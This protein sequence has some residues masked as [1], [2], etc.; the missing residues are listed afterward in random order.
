MSHIVSTI[1]K[2][3]IVALAFWM[4]A[5]SIS[6]SWAV[7]GIPQTTTL[8]NLSFAFGEDEIKNDVGVWRDA[9][10]LATGVWS[11]SGEALQIT[12][13]A[14]VGG[15][16]TLFL[17]VFVDDA[18]AQPSD[19][20]FYRAGSATT[21]ERSFT[22]VT[23][24]TGASGFRLVRVQWMSED[25]YTMGTRSLSV[26]SAPTEAGQSAQLAFTVPASGPP[27]P[28]TRHGSWANVPGLTTRLVTRE[29]GDLQITFS[30]EI[31][32]FKKRFLA[33]AVLDGA[34]AMPADVT[35]EQQDHSG[36][37]TR[38]M[39]F[40]R[41]NVRPGTHT[42]TIQWFTDPG[43]EIS[44]GDRTLSVLASVRGGKDGG[45]N[46]EVRET[47]PAKIESGNWTTLA[48]GVIQTG[49]TSGSA[50]VTTASVEH[51]VLGLGR[52]HMRVLVDD[53]VM[54]PGEIVLD[55]QASFGVQ[56]MVFSA[57]DFGPP[58]LLGGIYKISLQ[59]KVD[60]GFGNVG[61]GTVA[62]IR[63][64]NLSSVSVRRTGADFAQA[65]PLQ[66]GLFPAQGRFN[67]LTICFDPIRP[68][69]PPLTDAAV[70]N[71]V[72]GS[73]VGIS[74]RELY[75][76]TS[77]G[78][79]GIGNHTVLGCG[80]PTTY[81]PP[82]AHRGNYYWEGSKHNE[83][84]VQMRVDAIAAADPDFNFKQF[85][86]N[87]D[88]NILA[89]ELVINICIPQSNTP[90]FGQA[91]QFASYS[92]DGT[93]LGIATVDCYISPDPD[94]A[95]RKD[96]VGLIAHET[97]HQLEIAPYDLYGTADMPEHLSLMG[98]TSP[99]H[100]SAY[101]KLHYGWISPALIDMTAWT[102]RD[103]SIDAI[104]T[105]KEA[106]IVYNPTRNNTEYF[107]VENRFKGTLPGI[108]NYDRFIGPAAGPVLWHIV[109]DVN[110]LDPA[111]PP[112][113]AFPDD[114]QPCPVPRDP[115]PDPPEPPDP[116]TQIWKCRLITYGWVAGGIQNWGPITSRP[117]PLTWADGSSAG[118]TLVGV[119]VGSTS[120]VTFRKH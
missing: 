52:T 105:S 19:V 70:R 100:F 16:G 98:P 37:G 81:H 30:A 58:G 31:M 72:D 28:I 88:G 12:V 47:T 44:V 76:E 68:G 21:S 102:T 116:R 27:V 111:H 64:V 103:V 54:Q 71:I 78:R 39:T 8:G 96:A 108:R 26:R 106:V 6:T 43:G 49:I 80:T 85:D 55:R 90:V 62:E 4:S 11:R 120:V 110:A 48:S 113:T 20:A 61:A 92:V 82:P 38:S 87:H 75:R 73:D 65:Q 83:R 7:T 101:E 15:A 63:D 77:G 95:R 24:A 60:F 50:I 10:R 3:A 9:R 74:V 94:L 79:F 69:E 1:R 45:V 42:V 97:A 5:G 109:E 25:A 33:R 84:F 2:L 91:R 36:S 13:S 34:T 35:M 93:T 57:K 99:V 29:T 46:N 23:R 117:I 32:V 66:N 89:N 56:S 104:E 14:R 107:M 22:F 118:M 67:M 51:R 17:R 18:L 119:S 40:S 53:R 115:P 112:P 86:L 41:L 114:G 59:F